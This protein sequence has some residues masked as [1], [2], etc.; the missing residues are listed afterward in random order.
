MAAVAIVGGA[1]MLSRNFGPGAV[2]DSE[3]PGADRIAQ[4]VDLENAKTPEAKL[5]QGFPVG[6]PVEAANIVEAYSVPIT[7]NGQT[8]MQYTVSYTTEK[9]RQAKYDEYL[10]Y[11]TRQGYDFGGRGQDARNFT[12]YGI[13]DN[14]DLSVA[15]SP[16][17]VGNLVQISFIDR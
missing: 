9:S 1:Y 17:E 8:L 7:L 13:K 16:Q 10:S 15:V 14:D 11:M 6:I 3:T 5:P 12:L 2:R 4:H